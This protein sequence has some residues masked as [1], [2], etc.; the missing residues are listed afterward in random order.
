[1]ADTI[2]NTEATGTGPVAEG[3]N[4]SIQANGEKVFTQTELNDIVAKRI[5]QV[6]KKFADIDVDEYQQLRG[7]RDRVEEKELMERKDFE[8]LL[9]KTKE[10]SDSEVTSL[11]SQLE[12]IK[13]DGALI[14]AASK[15]K[16]IAP[17]QTAALLRG[18]LALDAGGN[19]VVKDADGQIR[20]NDNAEP[21]SVDQLVDEFLTTHGHF[22]AAGPSGTASESNSKISVNQKVDLSNLDMTRADHRAI[23]KEMMRKGQL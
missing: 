3:Q 13:L 6:N 8:T 4:E 9:K 7:L 18:Q 22:R 23:Y 16:S 10:K 14:N 5:A 20:Y 12:S 17:E 19:A 15:L 21:M 2:D 1:M 11:R